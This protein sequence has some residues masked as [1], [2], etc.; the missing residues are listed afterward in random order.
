MSVGRG[1]TYHATVEAAYLFTHSGA[2]ASHRDVTELFVIDQDARRGPAVCLLFAKRALKCLSCVPTLLVGL[3]N[4]LVPTCLDALLDELAL[5]LSYLRPQLL[6]VFAERGAP[7]S[8]LTLFFSNRECASRDRGGQE[9]LW[10]VGCIGEGS[11]DRVG[12]SPS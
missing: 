9:V 4:Y 12:L 1:G 5:R 7:L 10:K 2:V 8:P 6:E 11:C 3:G